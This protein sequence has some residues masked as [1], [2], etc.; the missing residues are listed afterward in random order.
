[1]RAKSVVTDQQHGKS[2]ARMARYKYA[3]VC[4]Q[5]GRFAPGGLDGLCLG[6][7]VAYN[8][9]HPEQEVPMNRK[10]HN[11]MLAFSSTGLVLLAGLMAAVSETNDA[12]LAAPAAQ[13]RATSQ[14]AAFP[15]ARFQAAQAHASA[16]SA[17]SAA[18]QA[19]AQAFEARLE[20]SASTADMLA[21]T[22][23]FTVEMA[24]EAALSAAFEQ[25]TEQEAEEQPAENTQRTHVRRSRAAL[26][27]PY[28][29]FAQGLRRNR[30]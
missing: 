25:A 23:A 22:A 24:T 5:L 16:I 11:S 2:F 12:A 28:F 18:L 6:V 7:I 10:L 15:Q 30:S 9:S 26:A 4:H 27:L 19:R 3:G 29:S 1:M 21:E 13:A 20:R 14:P 8:T 17:R